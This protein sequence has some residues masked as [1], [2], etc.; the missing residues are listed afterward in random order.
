MLDVSLSASRVVFGRAERHLERVDDLAGD[1]V[2]D[3]EDIG[4]VAIV[5]VGPQVATGG[6]VDELRGDP[7]AIAGAA[8]RAFEHRAHAKLAADGANVDERPL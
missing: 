7:H 3:L 2:L 8:D 1:V 5:A 4:Q 6:R